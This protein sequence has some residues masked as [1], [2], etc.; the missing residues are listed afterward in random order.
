MVSYSLDY[1]FYYYSPYEE[2]FFKFAKT[3]GHPCVITFEGRTVKEY[4]DYIRIIFPDGS[5]ST[6]NIKTG[7]EIFMDSRGR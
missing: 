3:K 7:I 5:H 2:G 4:K 1:I 6:R